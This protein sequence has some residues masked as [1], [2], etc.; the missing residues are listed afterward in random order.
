VVG[1]YGLCEMLRDGDFGGMG[2]VLDGPGV[3]WSFVCR[4]SVARVW[5]MLME[6]RLSG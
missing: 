3:G 6:N 5:E 4:M 2:D 1:V